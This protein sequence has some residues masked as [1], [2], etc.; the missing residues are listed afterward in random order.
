MS[1]FSDFFPT[2]YRPANDHPNR[3]QTPGE[4]DAH[5]RV[6]VETDA[7]IASFKAAGIDMLLVRDHF[8]GVLLRDLLPGNPFR[9]PPDMSALRQ[10]RFFLAC[11]H[12]R[13]ERL[14]DQ[15]DKGI[16]RHRRLLD[17]PGQV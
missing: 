2:T 17:D 1:E 6:V 14:G 9:D 10:D 16:A 13:V 12:D 8:A 7:L 4:R 11:L 15:Y 5:A 3:P